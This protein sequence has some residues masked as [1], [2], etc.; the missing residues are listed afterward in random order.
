VSPVCGNLTLKKIYDGVAKAVSKGLM[1]DVH[2]LVSPA[3]YAVLANDQASLR[4]YDAKYSSKDAENGFEAVSF[5]GQNGKIEILSH[6]MV[7][8]GEAIC[9]PK[10]KAERIGATDVTFQTPGTEGGEMFKHLPDSTGY[11]CRLYS[12]QAIFLPCPA[13]SVLF[14]GIT[15]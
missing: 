10:G 14:T 8:E 1:E 7:K 15:N 11:E 6:P 3:T 4:R 13:K 9:Y 5:Y 12:E 2:V